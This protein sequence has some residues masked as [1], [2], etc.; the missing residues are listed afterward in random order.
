MTDQKL[1]KELFSAYP[2]LSEI[3]LESVGDALSKSEVVTLEAGKPV[4][5]ELQPCG[6]FPFI[7]SGRIRVYKQSVQGRELSLYSVSRGD[8]CVVTAGCLLGDEPYNASG[9]VMEDS[10]LLMVPAAA[11]D[12]LLATKEFREFVFSLISERILGLMQL[13]EEVSFHKLDK[14]LASLLLRRGSRL[15]VSHQELADELGTVR[16]MVTRLLNG[17][18]ETGLIALG[19]GRIEIIDKSALKRLVDS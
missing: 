1:V 17:F 4:F 18:S 12:K 10:T 16:E 7:L 8:V 11:F 6:F 2:V 9:M 14:R 19:R 15:E 13:V 5:D 3:N